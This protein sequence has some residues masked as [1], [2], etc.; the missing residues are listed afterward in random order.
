MNKTIYK[1]K[2]KL[3]HLLG[4]AIQ[5]TNTNTLPNKAL[6]EVAYFLTFTTEFL[7]FE[8]WEIAGGC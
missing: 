5:Y 1:A 7:P 2:W 3:S 6:C 8:M 4:N